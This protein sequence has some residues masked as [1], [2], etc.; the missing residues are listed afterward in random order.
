MS[1]FQEQTL[2]LQS[3]PPE[4]IRLLIGF[5][6]TFNTTPSWPFHWRKYLQYR[7]M[8][9]FTVPFNNKRTLKFKAQQT[10]V[11]FATINQ[12]FGS[13]SQPPTTAERVVIKSL[14]T[15]Q[16]TKQ[17]SAVVVSWEKPPTNAFVSRL[18][19]FRVHMLLKSTVISNL[20]S[21]KTI[22]IKT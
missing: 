18:L 21:L 3:S 14:C 20:L 16:T 9:I 22:K 8:I 6:S 13:S 19:N 5:Q 4:I 17:C 7:S 2:Y 11:L 1:V 10:N 15:V 12:M